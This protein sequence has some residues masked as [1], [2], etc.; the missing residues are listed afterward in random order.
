[1]VE[2]SLVFSKSEAE[3]AGMVDPV[4]MGEGREFDCVDP[5]SLILAQPTSSSAANAVPATEPEF[6]GDGA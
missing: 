1:M 6:S 5:R 3:S 2:T 4:D